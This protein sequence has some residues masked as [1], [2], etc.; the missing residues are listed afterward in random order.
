MDGVRFTVP[1]RQLRATTLPRGSHFFSHRKRNDARSECHRR[2]AATVPLL[3]AARGREGESPPKIALVRVFS[4]DPIRGGLTNRGKPRYSSS[5]RYRCSLYPI[6]F[7]LSRDNARNRAVCEQLYR[8]G[9]YRIGA[10]KIAE[11][12]ENTRLYNI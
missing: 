4:R 11:N 2:R 10:P 9:G 5:R 1:E 3:P 6:P 7:P 8:S 12:I